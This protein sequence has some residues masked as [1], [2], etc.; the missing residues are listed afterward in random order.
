MLLNSSIE[1]P[2]DTGLFVSISGFFNSIANRC[3]VKNFKV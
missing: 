1:F 3:S 2:Q